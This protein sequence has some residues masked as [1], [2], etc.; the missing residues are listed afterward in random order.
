MRAK[1][2]SWLSWRHAGPRAGRK[3]KCVVISARFS[4]AGEK[5][6]TCTN[7]PDLAHLRTKANA[8]LLLAEEP[9]LPRRIIRVCDTKK[10]PCL[11]AALSSK[12]A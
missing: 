3:E 4:L 12:Q 1:C 10:I 8:G 7:L 6:C 2:V 5:N 11:K 9:N